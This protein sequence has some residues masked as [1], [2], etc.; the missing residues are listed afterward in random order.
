[1]GQIRLDAVVEQLEIRLALEAELTEDRAASLPH[2]RVARPAPHERLHLAWICAQDV[3]EVVPGEGVHEVPPG[4][5]DDHL[6]EH[7]QRRT[8]GTR[9]RARLRQQHRRVALFAKRARVRHKLQH[10]PLPLGGCDEGMGRE[11]VAAQP[12]FVQAP[13]RRDTASPTSCRPALPPLLSDRPPQPRR[14]RTVRTSGCVIGGDGSILRP[15]SPT[16]RRAH[17]PGGS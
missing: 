5:G 11:R 9:D 2:V 10:D 3:A 4:A 16:V 14:R 17:S 8:S 12:C 13:T 15:I 6:L 1:M 7:R